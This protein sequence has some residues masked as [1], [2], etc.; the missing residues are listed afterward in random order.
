M[1]TQTQIENDL[2]QSFVA[3]TD[4]VTDFVRGSVIRSIFTAVAAVAAEMWN[5]LVRVKR[6]IF[7][8]TS[9]GSQLDQIGARRGVARKGATKSSTIIVF[10][11][12]ASTTIPAGTEIRSS[13]GAAVYVTKY[14]VTIG[15]KNPGLNGTAN[16]QSLGD[17]VLAESTTTG[18]ASRVPANS[19]TILSQ[20]IP[21]VQSLINPIP[22]Q[23][24]DDTEPDDLYAK[25]MINY[26]SLLDQGTQSFFEALAQTANPNV[27]RAL[28]IRNPISRGISII[29][30]KDSGAIFTTGEITEIVAYV[31]ARERA[32]DFIECL[33]VAFTPI[34]VKFNTILEDGT[35]LSQVFVKVADALAN[36]VDWKRWAFGQ[37]VHD[38]DILSV[39]KTVTD[40]GDIDLESF[41]I[42]D[43]TGDI[44]VPS[45]SL[46]RLTG[47]SITNAISV[48]STKTETLVQSYE[49]QT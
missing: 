40:I 29:L 13:S 22:S 33:N 19:L 45:T 9:S 39:I 10:T 35:D 14:D 4:K 11:G 47:L 25:R 20:P 3:R 36:F 6:D 5:D 12:A 38:D 32:T 16:S 43:V 42:N 41:R 21:G 49:N 26:I 44:S 8:E 17:A 28:S 18:S 48:P 37:E 7:V 15:A 34:S 31:S 27:L 46:P 2:I 24:G 1:K 23:G 30:V